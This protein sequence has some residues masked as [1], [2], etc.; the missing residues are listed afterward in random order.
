MEE[1]MRKIENH[2]LRQFH[3][4]I[5]VV[6]NI[7]YDYIIKIT[8]NNSDVG[9]TNIVLENDTIFQPYGRLLRS[10]ASIETEIITITWLGVHLKGK[11]IGTLLLIYALCYVL[12][13]RPHIH[14]ARLD[15]DSDRSQYIRNIYSGLMF[16]QDEHTKLLNKG[17]MSLSGPEKSAYIGGPNYIQLLNKK[18]NNYIG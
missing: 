3:Y 5:V 16:A 4:N 13:K 11:G 10:A 6:H 9:Q 14:Y 1:I 2:L 8:H 18:V 17:Q 12:N 15:D 7:P